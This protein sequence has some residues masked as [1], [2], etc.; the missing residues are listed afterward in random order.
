MRDDL[1]RREFLFGAAAILGGVAG[2]SDSSQ[3]AEEPRVSNDDMI[4]IPA[5]EY[6]MGTTSEQIEELAT[7]YGFDPSWL[8]GETPQRR[9]HV[10]EFKIDR[11]PVT[12]A[13]YLEFVKDTRRRPPV[14]WRGSYPDEL[15]NHPVVGIDWQS[16]VACAEWAGKRL[17][18]EAEWEKAA[19]GTAGRMWPWGNEWDG[20]L[21]N[22]NEGDKAL[23]RPHTT[24][25]DRFPGGAS[26]YGVMDMVGNALEWCADEWSRMGR[27]MRGGSWR[28]SQP[29]NLRPA[30]RLY[31]QWLNN[32]QSWCG[33]RCAR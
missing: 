4:T 13:Q 25:V 5:G 6:L 18:T 3:A 7:K 27:P 15:G 10:A 11:F 16:A 8:S 31:G 23:P 12:N 30:C 33:F 26:P 28:H 20:S 19:R 2:A 22:W 24:P 29:Y 9:V 1:S 21:C 14:T 17:P 32:R